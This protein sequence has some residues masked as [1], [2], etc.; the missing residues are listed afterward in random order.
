MCTQ[1]NHAY[2]HTKYDRLPH[3]LCQP[4]PSTVSNPGHTEQLPGGLTCLGAQF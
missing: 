2:V 1:C 4:V 3:D